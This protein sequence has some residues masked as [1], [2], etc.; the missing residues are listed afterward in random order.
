MLL[1]SKARLCCRFC[2]FRLLGYTVKP[3]LS[4][5]LKRR[6]KNGFQDPLSLNAGQKYC[7]MLS[8]SILQYFRPSLSYN[9]LFR[10]LFCLILSG[11]LKTG[12]TVYG[13]DFFCYIRWLSCNIGRGGRLLVSIERS[14]EPQVWVFRYFDVQEVG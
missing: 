1:G 6:P 4:G 12:L 9:L 8:W 3:V 13:I 11:P 2:K 7:R 10:P 14:G 5:H